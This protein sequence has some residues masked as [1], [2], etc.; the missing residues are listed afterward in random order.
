M[1]RKQTLHAVIA[2]GR[3]MGDELAGRLTESE[4]A[5]VGTF[6]RWAPKDVFA[7]VAEWLA[8]DV[9]RLSIPEDPLPAYEDSTVEAENRAIFAQF[10]PE[11]W[12]AVIAF[13]HQTY[14]ETQK[15]VEG[16]SA[17]Q[18]DRRREYADG[19]SR[20][21]WRTI[22]GH[23]LMHAAPHFGLVYQRRGEPELATAVEETSAAELLPLDNSPQ[24][25]GTLKYN[26]ACHFALNGRAKH[27]IELLRV[28]LR[29]NSELVARS[30]EDTDLDPIRSD[31]E[32]AAV[33]PETE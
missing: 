1:E 24:W 10:A 31:P 30:R 13:F 3:R 20:E 9:R 28:A 17:V 27:A 25:I 29:H 16:L 18:I 11:N 23:A 7:H 19:S 14:D 26:L 8:R 2:C 4:R 6:E 21:V 12:D 33:Y 15:L 32:F 5:A 22:A